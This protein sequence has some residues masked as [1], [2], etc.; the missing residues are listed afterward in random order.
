MKDTSISVSDVSLLSLKV[1]CRGAGFSLA[2]L[3]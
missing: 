2:I 1:V 3:N